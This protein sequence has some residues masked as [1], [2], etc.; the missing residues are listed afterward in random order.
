M[1]I[2]GGDYDLEIYEKIKL[3]RKELGLSA[4]TVAEKLGISAATMYRYENNDIKKFPID[5]LKPLASVLHTT[6]EYLMG[7]TDDVHSAESENSQV[8]NA[9]LDAISGLSDEHVK[10]ALDYIDYL[11]SKGN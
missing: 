2:K 1:A 8:D 9:L 10:Q 6:P 4:E 3:R 7:W 11:K 5:I